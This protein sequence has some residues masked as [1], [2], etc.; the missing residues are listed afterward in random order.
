MRC[1]MSLLASAMALASAGPAVVAQPQPTVQPI[2]LG[3]IVVTAAGFEQNIRDAPASISVIS[4]EELAKKSY[5]GIVDAVNNIPGVY[6]TGG[7]GAQDISIRGMTSNY[8]LYL[9][10]GRP[11]SAGRSVNTNG[12]D[13]GKQI[14][15]PPISMIERVEVI[16]GPMS[17]LYGSEAMGGVINIITRKQHG[18]WSGTITSEYTRSFNDVSND[19]RQTSL[20][21][22]GALVDGLLS[23]Q[24]N[25]AWS[26]DD[27][28]DFAGADDAA[29]STPES[30][31]RQAGAKLTLT[32][33]A[34]NEFSASYDSS[35]LDETGTPGRS[36]AADETGSRYVYD[37]DVYVLSHAGNYGQWLSRSFVQHDVSERVQDQ[38]K[39]EQV[40][41]VDS[42]VTRFLGNHVVTVGGQYKQEK[43]TD[44][45][46]GLLTAG[47]PGAVRSVDRWI[48]AV[49][50]EVEW[51]VT[52]R[53]SVT[54]GL[55]YNDDEL[56]GGELSPRVYAL[57]DLA[58]EWTLKGGVS[59]GYRQ[60]GL[61]DATEGFGRGTG[62]SGSP[63][64]HPRAL[65]I[66]N[67]ELDPE[68]STSYEAGGV[69]N[70]RAL[71]LN[72]SLMVFHT[73]FED[74]IAEDRFCVSP[75]GDSDDPATWTCSFGGNDYLFL[76]TRSNID[77]AEMRGVELTLDYQLTDA[78][79]LSSSYTYTRSEQKTGEFQGEPL[80]KTPRHMANASLDWDANSRLNLWLQANYRG[81]TSDYL[82]RTSMAAGTP[83][84]TQMDTGMLYR[85]TDNARVTAGLYNLANKKITNDEYGVVLDGRRLA[86]GLTVDF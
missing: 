9:V 76:S 86:L 19:A 31:R 75:A 48:A 16:R 28:S 47:I 43:L 15:L 26:G 79:T 52:D 85:L 58:P 57:Y 56:F 60:P 81:E 53:L 82:D 2:E 3:E 33:D 46:N 1:R 62:G 35:R 20:F 55:R 40:S 30:K 21:T 37:K 51:G 74:K 78:L 72:A 54:T 29:R 65:I 66:G 4:G 61:A 59:T 10:D 8:T 84:Y 68:S 18:E 17:S 50:A 39:K 5:T 67:P 14:A 41:M 24:L 13:G 70:N 36:I 69:Y 63:A 45:T 64:P 11:V 49:Y 23:A 44:E 77:E 73:E 42:Q 34:R 7:G 32:P 38:T 71:G 25:A 12:Q 22:G 6:V 27:E 80:N 83:A